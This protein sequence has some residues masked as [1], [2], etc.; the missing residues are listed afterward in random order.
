MATSTTADRPRRV[1]LR[2]ALAL[3]A[4]IALTVTTAARTAS[5]TRGQ[6]RT[7]NPALIDS[8]AIFDTSIL[9]RISITVE[10]GYLVALDQQLDQRVPC[11][12]V[13]DGIRFPMAGIR[14]KGGINSLTDMSDKP[15][16][17]I[18]LNAFYG[19]QRLGD[20]DK[21]ILNNG[22]QDAAF[23]NE[24]LGYGL[25]RRAGLIAPRTAHAL[26]ELNGEPF[27]IYVLREA[28]D[29]QFLERNFGPRSARGNLY[30]GSCPFDDPCTDFV[31]MPERM[32]LKRERRDNRSR[33][34][35]NR[36]AKVIRKTPGRS[37]ESRIDLDGFITGYAID[38]L[39]GHWDSYAYNMNNYFLF[40]R[41]A[42]GRFVFIPHGMDS[43]F[44][45]DGVY[46]EVWERPHPLDRP[47]G[48]LAQRVWERPPLRRRFEHELRRI[49]AEVWQTDTM[50]AQI[51]QV[52]RVI[53]SANAT[54]PNTLHDLATFDAKI[55]T[56]IEFISTRATGVFSTTRSSADSD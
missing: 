1:P 11:T 43:V 13:F 20:L 23:V 41:P 8:S 27:G 54:D 29:R 3:I 16:L 22:K 31:R 15:S 33:R 4:L 39:T 40:H 21:L 10:Q 50:L 49:L 34:D 46:D 30:E 28:I 37:W 32:E 14:R 48:Y 51:E 6:P 9:H 7:V 26:V 53:H 25:Y 47:E 18:K 24:H 36:L 38:A 19:R 55:G 5:E 17:S 52:R 56:I 45:V 2:V 35:L 42:D 12:F 44:D